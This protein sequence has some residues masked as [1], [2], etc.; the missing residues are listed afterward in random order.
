MG[1]SK[2][3]SGLLPMPKNALGTLLARAVAERQAREL[4]STIEALAAL[5]RLRALRVSK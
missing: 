4:R 2:K 3:A 1:K 5:K